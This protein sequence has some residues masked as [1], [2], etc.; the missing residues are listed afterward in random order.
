MPF[1][2]N[3]RNQFFPVGDID[4]MC[5]SYTIN[6]GSTVS[7]RIYLKSD[8]DTAIEVDDSTI[9]QAL[10]LSQSVMPAQPGYRL[11]TFCFDPSFDDPP[12]HTDEPILGWRVGAY[13]SIEPMVLDYE[14]AEM[15]S[16]HAVMEPNGK[17]HVIDG[18]YDT[19]QHWLM[20]MAKDATDRY[21]RRLGKK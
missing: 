21:R 11:L 13:G 14:F 7:A 6:G 8:P 16:D 18:C 20:E 4:R 10:R 2:D 12:A 1:F 17:V 15:N 3:G 9:D 5:K 19:L